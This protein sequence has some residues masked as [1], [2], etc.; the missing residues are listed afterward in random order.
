MFIACQNRQGD[1]QQFC[2]HENQSTPPSLSQ[3]NCLRS[4]NK[5]D[6]LNFQSKNHD[7]YV[8]DIF[9]ADMAVIDG[10]AL[11]NLCPDLIQNQPSMNM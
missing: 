1:L 6:L 8:T 4:G 11:V 9:Q 7:I 10:A 3:G 2:L 5:A